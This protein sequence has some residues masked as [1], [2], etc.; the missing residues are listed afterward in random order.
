[1]AM[2]NNCKLYNFLL[3]KQILF[4]AY[5]KYKYIRNF[6]VTEFQ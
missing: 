3:Q 5:N 6:M 2:V 1:M 4:S